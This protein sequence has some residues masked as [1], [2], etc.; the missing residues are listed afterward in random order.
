M[1]E[2]H[3]IVRQVAVCVCFFLCLF[4]FLARAPHEHIN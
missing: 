3:L 4:L 1:T 2:V